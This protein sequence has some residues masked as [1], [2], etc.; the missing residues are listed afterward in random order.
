[1]IHLVP[2]TFGAGGIFGGAERYALE[3]ARHMADVVPT[4][5]ISFGLE[6]RRER[7]GRLEVRVLGK[8]WH[9]RGQA[10][11]P[12]HPRLL[13]E[14]AEAGVIHCHQLHVLASSISALVARC[15]GTRVFVSDL[16][17]G[18]WDISGYLSTNNWY[19][20]HLHISQYSRRISG[21]HDWGRAG[22]ILGGVDT[23]RFQPPSAEPARREVLFVGRLM[24][25]KGVDDL[26][27]AVPAEIPLRVI[28][29]PYNERFTQ[30]LQQ[31]AAGKKVI[32][33]HNADDAGIIRAYQN[34][35]CIVLPSVYR[36]RYGDETKVPELL[37]QT[38]LEGMACGAPGIC[39]DV[40]SM[41]EIVQDGVN[42]FIVPP[43]NP[44]ALR[45]KLRW[46]AA[47]PTEVQAMGRAAR[48]RIESTFTWPAVV[49]RCLEWYSADHRRE[50]KI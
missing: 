39:T 46:L 5:L 23:S 38:L 21:H 6:D 29:R 25:H 41:P 30:D 24:P 45:E 43:N 48:A 50:G 42:G 9:V 35:L 33:E 28:G 16:G 49:Q 18:G 40:A 8:P 15:S 11:N 37:G 3:L 10:T 47:H 17:G 19:H 22:V 27:E 20:G 14:L 12:F 34:A 31:L 13:L 44:A 2:A 32:F 4:R 1:M 26:V 36:T 7:V